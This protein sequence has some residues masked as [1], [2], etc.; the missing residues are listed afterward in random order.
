MSYTITIS[1]DSTSYTLTNYLGVNL[2][3]KGS[4][5]I[6]EQEYGSNF[7]P[8]IN[9][10]SFQIMFAGPPVSLML[11]NKVQVIIAED[12]EPLFTGYIRP[13]SKLEF[14]G[15]GRS[16][17]LSVEC[18]GCMSLLDTA[19][20]HDGEAVDLGND[21]VVCNPSDTA[22]SYV[23]VLLGYLGWTYDLEAPLIDRPMPIARLIKGDDLFDKLAH[24]LFCAGHYITELPS[25]KLVIKPYVVASPAS[26]KTFSVAERNIRQSMSASRAESEES[27]V[28]VTYGLYKEVA[29]YA[30]LSEDVKHVIYAHYKGIFTFSC[31]K[32]PWVWPY[33][34]ASDGTPAHLYSSSS[35]RNWVWN[36]RYGVVQK[37]LGDDGAE[38]TEDDILI[39]FPDPDA[40]GLVSGMWKYKNIRAELIFT[41]NAFWAESLIF[42]GGWDGSCHRSGSIKVVIASNGTIS[43]LRNPDKDG[44]YSTLEADHPLNGAI[45]AS[46]TIEGL[47]L[48]IS[49][50]SYGDDFH[51]I[52]FEGYTFYAS[53][54]YIHSNADAKVDENAP[55]VISGTGKKKKVSAELCFQ[56]ADAEGISKALLVALDAATF[57]FSSAEK[58]A[59]GSLVLVEHTDRGVSDVGRIVSRTFGIEKNDRI[60]YKI[61]ALSEFTIET[62]Y[63]PEI[64]KQRGYANP[65]AAQ[66]AALIA[67]RARQAEMNAE[68][69]EVQSAISALTQFFDSESA[70][71][72]PYK[73]GD[74]WIHDSA[75]YIS[76]TTRGEGEGLE[77]DWVW[78]IRPNLLTVVE[79]TNGDKFKPGLSTTTTLFPRIFKNGI[80]ITN[81]L[82][83]SS[84]RWTR[85]S[86]FSPNDDAL[87]NS[88]H[89]NGYRT[90]EVTTDTINARATYTLEIL[91]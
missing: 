39:A 47:N 18:L 59:S 15:M 49:A 2:V 55:R 5:E 87:W 79:S 50:P 3:M 88:N 23:H 46:W 90:V 58:E 43:Y 14:S 85:K 19:E 68:I 63:Y 25:G 4:V 76:T 13:L 24:V 28:A 78:Y 26:E 65:T 8:V 89:A 1:K 74:F 57:E 72:G 6:R 64:L 54:E 27:A 29:E 33:N 69:E 44:N 31:D 86:F 41:D 20:E 91:E 81:T 61:E 45:T 51:I 34:L 80:E 35:C 52:Y 71:T 56:K 66:T 10:A 42:N 73:E 83:D 67:D 16:D 62:E 11:E 36:S 37:K 17:K 9:S 38:T 48:K 60:T 77:T 22:A 75:I 82:P 53:L 70:P 7:A 30:I 40:S 84:F 21:L 32:K 12:G